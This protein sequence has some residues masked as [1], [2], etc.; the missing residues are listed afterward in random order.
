MMPPKLFL[1]FEKKPKL[2]FGEKPKLLFGEKPKLLFGDD[3]NRV[4]CFEK[5]HTIKQ[6]PAGRR[7]KELRLLAG[8]KIVAKSFDKS[9]V[10]QTKAFAREVKNLEL[11]RECSFVPEV[12]AI[13]REK[14]IIYSRFYGEPLEKYT[15]E[16]IKKQVLEKIERLRTKYKLMRR[17]H[18]TNLLPRP[19][20]VAVDKS[21]Q[22]KIM[23][24]GP[25]YFQP[26]VSSFSIRIPDLK[27]VT[28]PSP[29][30]TTK[31]TMKTPLKQVQ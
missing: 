19:S 9:N 24:L 29:K 26:L 7:A 4:E 13:D 22:V 20:A 16:T 23:D 12:L 11:A 17:W 25:S 31:P 30:P 18:S 6:L 2:L 5:L 21:G 15:D 1:L 28:K 14:M 8:G 27:K 3:K 10:H